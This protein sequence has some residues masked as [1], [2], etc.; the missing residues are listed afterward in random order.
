M[1]LLIENLE[2]QKMNFEELLRVYQIYQH[3]SIYPMFHFHISTKTEKEAFNKWNSTWQGMF[4]NKY[5][6]CTQGIYEK[7]ITL[8]Q[9]ILLKEITKDLNISLKGIKEP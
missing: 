5:K 6:K 8:I 7:F 9:F 1:M 2:D 3:K 4:R